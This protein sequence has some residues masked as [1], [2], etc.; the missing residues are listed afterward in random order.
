MHAYVY[1]SGAGR[2][3]DSDQS[4]V[5]NVES[6]YDRMKFGRK[7]IMYNV[8]W[9]KIAAYTILGQRLRVIEFGCDRGR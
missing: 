7:K 4:I 3:V 8:E 9:Q 6:T 1:I 5:E 2:N